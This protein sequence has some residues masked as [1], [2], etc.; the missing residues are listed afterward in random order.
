MDGGGE[1]APAV[2]EKDRDVVRAEVGHG[3]IGIA[4]TVKVADGD[5]KRLHAGGEIDRRRERAAAGGEEN[6][7]AV[8]AGIGNGQ[9]APAVV[10]QVADG[11]RR[12]AGSRRERSPDREIRTGGETGTGGKGDCEECCEGPRIASAHLDFRKLM[13][14]RWTCATGNRVASDTGRG[15]ADGVS[16]CRTPCN[17]CV[18]FSGRRCSR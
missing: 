7:N 2:A 10:I 12:R 18:L 4:I 8:R 15:G 6:G 9:I 14:P 5:P 3:E 13:P 16:F 1:R 17:G 11:D